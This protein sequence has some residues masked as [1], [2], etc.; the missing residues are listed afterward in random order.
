MLSFNNC[1]TQIDESYVFDLNKKTKYLNIFLWTV[2][3]LNKG[4]KLK[5]L[6]IGY[7]SLPLHECIVDCWNVSK[8]ETQTTINFRPIE[9]LKASAMSRIIKS[10]VLAS[11]PGFDSNIAVG[12]LTLNIQ[13]KLID[14]SSENNN[15]NINAENV[16]DL[17]ELNQNVSSKIAD[18][19]V[20]QKQF[21]SEMN[22]KNVESNTINGYSGPISDDDGSIHKFVNVSFN[23]ITLCEFCNK[24]VSLHND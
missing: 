13:H 2:Q 4:V 22:K 5:N 8:G 24:K 15:E 12:S 7:I 23:D 1:A 16:D 6:L 18:E 9:E 19:L 10:H 17:N 20:G 14:S 21:E 11:H 3:Y